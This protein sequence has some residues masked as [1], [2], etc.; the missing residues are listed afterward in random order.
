V[1]S[2]KSLTHA[3]RRALGQER[4]QVW[5]LKRQLERLDAMCLHEGTSRTEWIGANIDAE[6][7]SF[8]P[9][10]QQELTD[11]LHWVGK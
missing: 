2:G 7:D 11:E 3:E 5:I 1:S 6:W 4:L 10:V 8:S 9:R